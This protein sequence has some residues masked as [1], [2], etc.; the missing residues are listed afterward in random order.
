MQPLVDA[1]TFSSPKQ[2][3]DETSVESVHTRLF[4]SKFKLVLIAILILY[5]YTLKF[6][7]L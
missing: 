5:T 1:M 7:I 3:D 4:S 6:L 2:I